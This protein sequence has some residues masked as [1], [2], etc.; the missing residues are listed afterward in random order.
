RCD[1]RRLPEHRRLLRQHEGGGR[2]GDRDD[3]DG[4]D[5][6]DAFLCSVPLGGG[7]GRGCRHGVVEGMSM[8]RTIDS[9]LASVSVIS[10]AAGGLVSPLP[11]SPQLVRHSPLLRSRKR[12]AMRVACGSTGVATGSWRGAASTDD[13]MSRSPLPP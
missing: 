10:T 11:G 2:G 9:P 13:H 12:K 4:G 5:G 8:S 6:G 3:E 1:E 7:P